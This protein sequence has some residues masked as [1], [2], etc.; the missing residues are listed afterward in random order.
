MGNGWDIFTR[1]G[2]LLFAMLLWGC[3]QVTGQEAESVFN[4]EDAAYSAMQVP[5]RMTFCGDTID[6][7]RLDRKERMDREML[8][9]MYMHSNSVQ[10]IKRAG[11]YMAVIERILKEEGMPDDLKYLMV[12]ES[13]INPT[14]LS[15]AGAAGL[16]Q[17]MPATARQYGL[18]VTEAVDERYHLERA[19]RAAC[20]YLREAYAKYG[21]WETVAASY[22]AGQGK[23]SRELSRQREGN[24]LD[25]VLVEE[26]TRYVY[27]I[28]V[29]K[30]LLTDPEAFGF[31]LRPSDIYRPIPCKEVRVT[32][33][34]PD[35]VAFAKKHGMSYS[36]LRWLN[37][38]IRGYALPANAKGWTVLTADEAA[39]RGE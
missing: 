27:R 11:R 28:L 21:N 35:V 2:L 29:A 3:T 5:Q 17:L 20:K 30:L 34:V 10:V 7:S 18:T 24:A 12:T 37:P 39:M 16:W 38:W 9:A 19:T 1:G 26:T 32:T 6:L 23:I 15:R 14:A 8:A 36:T 25:L 31:R 33:A 22:N 4:A 13:N